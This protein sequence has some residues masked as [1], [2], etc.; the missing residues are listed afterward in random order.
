MADKQ[1]ISPQNAATD[2]L[3]VWGATRGRG[4]VPTPMNPAWQETLHNSG[5]QGEARTIMDNLGNESYVTVV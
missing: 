5:L 3:T 4:F 1:N 2:P